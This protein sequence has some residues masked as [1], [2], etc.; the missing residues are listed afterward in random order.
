MARLRI[1]TSANKC[2]RFMQTLF[3]LEINKMISRL[4]HDDRYIHFHN[5]N[6][7]DTVVNWIKKQHKK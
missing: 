7:A 3:K 5:E 6:D 1:Q 4:S 2:K